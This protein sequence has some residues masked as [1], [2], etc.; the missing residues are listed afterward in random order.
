MS[1]RWS[2]SWNWGCE[3]GAKTGRIVVSADVVGL[4]DI[5]RF[6]YSGVC[7]AYLKQT[8]S[9]GYAYSGVRRDYL[10]QAGLPGSVI[11]HESR[12]V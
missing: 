2:L 11:A 1:W 10:V 12:Q 9:P 3:A 5:V 6:A 7:C 4:A 8:S